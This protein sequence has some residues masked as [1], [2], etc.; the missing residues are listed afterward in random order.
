[1]MYFSEKRPPWNMPLEAPDI[2]ERVGKML[3]KTSAEKRLAYTRV[4][5]ITYIFQGKWTDDLGDAFHQLDCHVHLRTTQLD[6]TV[7]LLPL[8]VPLSIA[9]TFSSNT[10]FYTSYSMMDWVLHFQDAATFR[11]LLTR[12]APL[13][14][15]FFR[16]LGNPNRD[17]A[18]RSARQYTLPAKCKL[19][20]SLFLSIEVI[21][22]L[23]Q[24]GM[25]P[26]LSELYLHCADEQ[27]FTW[28]EIN[29]PLLFGAF[30]E[31]QVQHMLSIYIAHD[32]YDIPRKLLASSTFDTLFPVNRTLR[33]L[34]NKTSPEAVFLMKTLYNRRPAPITFDN[35]MTALQYSAQVGNRPM[36]TALLESGDHVFRTYTNAFPGFTTIKWFGLKTASTYAR[37]AKH[38]SLATFI[39]EWVF[40]ECAID[41]PPTTVDDVEK[42]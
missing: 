32:I 20:V 29:L 40:P 3:L 36:V 39:E 16:S 15:V 24:R 17:I 23:S 4:W 25:D 30:S 13:E 27:V 41:H 38:E 26:A 34:L 6:P 5:L 37:E 11:F 9:P 21:R 18:L 31:D 19:P 1:M 35:G 8:G 2:Q 7:H 42:K 22:A 10:V 28:C 14:K 33:I 12:G